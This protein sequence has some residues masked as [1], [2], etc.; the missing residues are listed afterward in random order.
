MQ[1]GQKLKREY[2]AILSFNVKTLPE[3]E[4]LAK[5]KGVKIIAKEV[6]YHLEGAYFEYRDWCWE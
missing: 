5:E 6:I 2:A 1:S 4:A 3:A